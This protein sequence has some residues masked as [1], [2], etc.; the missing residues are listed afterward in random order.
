M[1]TQ[2][3]NYLQRNIGTTAVTLITC[4]ANNQLMINQLSCANTLTI[5]VTCSVTLIR[6][7]VTTFL[8]NSASVPAGGSL[9]CAGI[10]QKLVLMAGD[11]I[12]IQSSTAASIDAIASG[13][14]NDFNRSAVVPAPAAAT[15]ATFSIAPNVT[16]LFEGGTVTYTITTTD[17]PNGTVVYWD[18]VGTVSATDFTDDRND[19]E[20]VINS[21]TGSF[22]RTLRSTDRVGEGSE[23]IVMNLRFRPGFVGGG[24]VATAATVTLRDF[25]VTTDLILHLDAGNTASYPGSGTTW[26]DLSGQGRNGTFTLGPVFNSANGGSIAFDDVDDYVSIPFAPQRIN[27]SFS[28]FSW[29]F[30]NATPT[31]TTKGIWGHYAVDSRNCHFETAGAGNMRIRLGDVNNVSLPAFPVGRWVY[32]GFTTTGNTHRYYVDGNLLAT[33]TGST[34]AVL[35]NTG[36]APVHT[37]GRSDDT[38]TWNGRIATASLYLKT[39]T[40]AEILQ[41]YS[42]QRD[43]FT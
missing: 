20:I 8:V 15:Q 35:G 33:W 42:A 37:V 5:P 34:G 16:T 9:A 43:R 27:Q 30:L 28:Y 41:N 40:D 2:F 31:G 32:A 4:P 1:F 10:D 38:R 12:Q 29:A 26:T 19:G 7:G 6:A 3:Q 24:A 14:L 13:V 18:N 25:I 39:L 22:T 23:T 11:V 17:V 21:G 36:V